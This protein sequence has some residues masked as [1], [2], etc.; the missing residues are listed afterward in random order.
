MKVNKRARY[1]TFLIFS[2]YAVCTVMNTAV[3]VAFSWYIALCVGLLITDLA[4]SWIVKQLK[5]AA[6]DEKKGGYGLTKKIR[7]K[8]KEDFLLKPSPVEF[9]KIKEFEKKPAVFNKVVFMLVSNVFAILA[10]IALVIR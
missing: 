8:Q 10:A 6:D 1:S 4:G 5:I 3:Y 2:V 9:A 7:E